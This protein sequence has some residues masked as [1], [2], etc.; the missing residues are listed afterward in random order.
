[1]ARRAPEM[2]DHFLDQN[3]DASR[4][5][6]TLKTCGRFGH[7]ALGLGL[8]HI[9]L[10][11]VS[12]GKCGR[13]PINIDHHERGMRFRPVDLFGNETAAVE[14]PKPKLA[15]ARRA[16]ERAKVD[17]EKKLRANGG[18]SSDGAVDAGALFWGQ[19]IE[20]ISDV[21]EHDAI[22]AEAFVLLFQGIA[23]VRAGGFTG[24][25]YL[26]ASRALHGLGTREEPQ[27][28]ASVNA[29]SGLS[30]TFCGY[31]RTNAR[32]SPNFLVLNA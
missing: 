27:R 32:D 20:R 24:F 4:I 30:P 18:K 13:A 10:E 17:D 21:L 25:D 15:Q 11:R 26:H 9:A 8:G 14:Q 31:R 3:F 22:R 1:M 23:T 6:S 2:G 5:L 29:I 19:D 28:N 16:G 7:H 12:E